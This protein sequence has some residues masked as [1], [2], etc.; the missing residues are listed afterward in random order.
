MQKK[1]RYDAG[2]DIEEIEGGG[3]GGGCHGELSCA[4]TERRGRSQEADGFL[5]VVEEGSR[6]PLG[7][8]V[9]FSVWAPMADL[10][11]ASLGECLLR[12]MRPRPNRPW[13]W[14][15]S[16][17]QRAPMRPAI[18]CGCEGDVGAGCAAEMDPNHIFQMFMNQGAFGGGGGGGP[19]G[20]MHFRFQ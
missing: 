20:G 8:G 2:Q 10:C 12:R 16:L 17:M 13:C 6:R 1:R 5:P 18:P 14:Q 4:C 9:C 19:G 3:C 7:I 15:R 11:L